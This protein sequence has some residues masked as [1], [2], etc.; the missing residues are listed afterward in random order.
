MLLVTSV[1]WGMAPA[2]IK[3][4]LTYFTPLVFLVY[5]FAISSAVGVAAIAVGGHK[6]PHPTRDV[7]YM[8]LYSILAVPL[9]LGLLFYGFAKTDSL[10]GNLL[11]ATGPLMIILLS[12]LF[13]KERVTKQER[14]GIG[15]AFAGTILTVVAPFIGGDGVALGF[16]EGNLLILGGV[17]GDAVAAILVKVVMREKV[18]ATLLT[19]TSF[20]IGF[21][22]LLPIVLW[23][24]GGTVIARTILQAP[25]S[26]HLGV[27]YMAILSGT[28]AYSLRNR[29]V[30]SIEVSESAVFS[31]LHPVW[32]APLSVAW[33]REV[34]TAQYLVGAMVIAAG[35][36]VAEHKRRRKK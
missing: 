15:L 18:S 14:L 17:V 6:V 36:A 28:L 5:R 32:G 31:Y 2:V 11:S 21:L 9:S 12:V 35:V 20:I 8:L 7:P 23:M 26:A 1:I 25:L 3:Y 16:V 13:L 34:I 22:V 4:T 27:L 24:Y 19:H 30:R 29:A 33:L 10:T